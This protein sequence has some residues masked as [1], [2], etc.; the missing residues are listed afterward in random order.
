M[1][2]YVSTLV[3]ENLELGEY[4]TT[5]WYDVFVAA[6]N[7]F[8]YGI[9]CSA[10][11]VAKFNPVDKSITHI[12]PDFG[13]NGENEPQFM[14]GLRGAITDS[15]IIYCPPHL[16]C[17][18]HRRGILK[19]DTNT[20]NVTELDVDL[21]PERGHY[22][23]DSCWHSCAAA[24]DGCMYFMPFDA[25]HIMKL[26]PNN[27]DAMSSVGDD[28]GSVSCYN[29]YVSTIIGIDGCVYGV[30][31]YSNCIVK[32]DPI[33]DTTSFV[34]EVADKEFMCSGGVLARDGCIYA[35][36]T[37]SRVLKI[38]TT[39]NYHCFVG[40]SIESHHYLFSDFDKGWGNAILGIDGCIYW[41][42]ADASRILKYDPH[43]N[44]ASLVGDDYEGERPYFEGFALE[45]WNGGCL[46]SD[47][48]IYCFPGGARRILTIDPW[49]EYLMTVKNN[50]EEHPQHFGLLFER[51]E[52][53]ESSTLSHHEPSID[54]HAAPRKC[55]NC[56][57][58][59]IKFV[60]KI[61]FRKRALEEHMNTIQPPLHHVSRINL[62][63]AVVKFGQKKA[64]EALE[65]HMAPV[66]D[67]CE[68]SNLCPFM[69]V[70]SYK[71]SSVCTIN[72]FLCQDL[73]SWVSGIGSLEVK[74]KGTGSAQEKVQY[75]PSKA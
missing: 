69:I 9:P 74:A 60:Q 63:H 51:T 2:N 39:N 3:G 66:N 68:R 20:D 32:Y 70:A 41:P 42:P 56:Y 65:K 1:A 10:R 22:M 27:N 64:I 23:W 6:A 30:P 26:D 46:A 8:L 48:V 57:N 50:I 11:Q 47:G 25:H 28:L 18:S 24:L 17:D 75:S 4:P 36:A 73:S 40:N 59:I 16:Y 21:L 7:G 45:I 71:E 15:G 62:D 14:F 35:L 31:Y 44:Q 38:D 37:D 13:D 34:G 5:D 33:N 55:T 72:H 43:T 58:A 52:E 67:F 53:R 12:G 29:K 61:G 19:I 54:D 49:K